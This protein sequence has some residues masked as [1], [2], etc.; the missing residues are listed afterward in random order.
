MEIDATT[1]LVIDDNESNI[2]TLESLLE[3]PGRIFLTATSGKA[4]LKMA[5]SKN[6]DLIILDVQ[7]PEMNG[8]EVAQV[9]KSNNR[10]KDIP[11]IFASAEMKE[12]DSI[13]K[14]FNEGAFDYLSKPLDPELTKAKVSVLLQLQL[15]RKE[16]VDKNLS[17]Q[18][19]EVQIKKHLQE[20]ETLNKELE[21]FS[22]S[23]SHDLRSPLR[24][25]KGYA[26]ILQ[27]DFGDKIGVEGTKLLSIIQQNS[28][29]MDDLINDLLEFSKL[30]RRQPV[31]RLVDIHE[32]VGN[33]IQGI[34][35]ATPHKA[36]IEIE[37]LLPVSCDASLLQQVWVNLIT[38]AIKYSSKKEKPEVMIGCY[39]GDSDI[40]YF[41]KDNGVGFDMSYADKLFKVFQRLHTDTEF[42][43]SGI[44]LALVQKIVSRQGG[45]VWA[46]AI[47]GYGATFYF[48][49]PSVQ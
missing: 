17:L 27:D 38:N 10:T 8:F 14:G 18:Q 49:L 23:V 11:I 15:Q 37:E 1:I 28:A 9:L 2:N 34:R 24:S 48:S 40:T 25:I 16:L 36:S 22:Y 6:V 31:K 12:R 39:T 33:V 26:Q 47:K 7:M 43:G 32:L 20:V 21:S 3:K 35:E 41:V 30:G 5:L 46:E 44:G 19:A 4:G 13:M 42:E 45:R 29:R